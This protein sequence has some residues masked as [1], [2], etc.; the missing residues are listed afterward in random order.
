MPNLT[1]RLLI[2][3]DNPAITASLSAIFT[4]LGHQVR[5][6]TDGISA[7]QQIR[8]QVPDIL[9][10]DL[11]MP[12]MSGFE[13]LSIVRRRL[14]GVFVIAFSAAFSGED[15]PI[16]LAA[17]AFHPK[18]TG[19][20]RLFELVKAATHKINVRNESLA[21]TP[22]W[23]SRTK[24]ASSAYE[25]LAVT[26]PECLR[27]FSLSVAASDFVIEDADCVYCD[28]SIHYGV[29]PHMNSTVARPPASRMAT[30]RQ[31]APRSIPIL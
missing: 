4:Q 22:I 26:C 6:A 19:L 9:L 12:Q 31:V 13:L 3:D 17:D 21:S 27:S 23:I 20:T 25:R 24:D 14:P 5:T 16:G 1:A 28:A 18:A 8:T 11:N 29:V 10:S 15:V 7:L 30:E 2:V